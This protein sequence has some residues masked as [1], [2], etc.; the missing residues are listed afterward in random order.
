ML[1]G[2]SLDW[3]GSEL[4]GDVADPADD[5]LRIVLCKGL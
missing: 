5:M 3:V 2:E 4:A 1:F